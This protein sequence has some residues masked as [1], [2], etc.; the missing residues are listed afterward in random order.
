MQNT[1]VKILGQGIYRGYAEHFHEDIGTGN[2]PRLC[3]TLSEDIGS[4]KYTA[5]LQNTLIPFVIIT[6]KYFIHYSFIAQ[7]NMLQA[8]QSE[9]EQ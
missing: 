5:G 2:I 1:F 6:I 4:R 3:R 8:E 9:H 7:P